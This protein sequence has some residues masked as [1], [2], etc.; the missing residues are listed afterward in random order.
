MEA[1]RPGENNHASMEFKL[2]V[3]PESGVVELVTQSSHLPLMFTVV[4]VS[5][6]YFLTPLVMVSVCAVAPNARLT[7]AAKASLLSII[8]FVTTKFGGA[9]ESAANLS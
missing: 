1:L 8:N 5:E 6:A 9:R 4:L 2:T 7:A 3:Q